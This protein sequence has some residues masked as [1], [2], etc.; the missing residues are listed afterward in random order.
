MPPELKFTAL[1]ATRYAAN[2]HAFAVSRAAIATGGDYFAIAPAGRSRRPV[3][4]SP[5]ALAS[6]SRPRSEGCATV[7]AIGE[8]LN[9]GTNCGSC[10]GEVARLVGAETNAPQRGGPFRKAL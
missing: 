7:A 1:A 2:W 8:R 5:N 10:R 3:P 6:R 4:G 9:A